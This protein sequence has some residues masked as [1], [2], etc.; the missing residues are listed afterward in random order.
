M[1]WRRDERVT[2]LKR[3]KQEVSAANQKVMIKV[4]TRT[5]AGRLRRGERI[6]GYERGKFDRVWLSF[7]YKK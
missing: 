6:D 3:E 4:R 1:I 5:M 2:R 7:G